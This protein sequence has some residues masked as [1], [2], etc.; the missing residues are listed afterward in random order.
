MLTPG[1][2][3][4]PVNGQDGTALQASASREEIY[5]EEYRGEA[6]HPSIAL[7]WNDAVPDGADRLLRMTEKQ[8]DHRRHLEKV[9]VWGRT[10]A[11]NLGTLGAVAITITGMILGYRLIMADKS[12][13]GLTAMFV[14]LAGLAAVYIK[15]TSDQRPKPTRTQASKKPTKSR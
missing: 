10:I 9:L 1:K 14:P 11:T 12:A 7:G 2:A 3:T 5:I 6:P 8:G 4:T 15:N 13:A